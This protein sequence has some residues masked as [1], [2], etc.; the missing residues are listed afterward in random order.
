M[1][2]KKEEFIEGAYFHIYNH[3]AYNEI[4]FPQSE[5]YEYFLKKL[6]KSIEKIPVSIIAYCLMPNHFHFFVRQ[7]SEIPIYK[8]FNLVSLS[9]VRHYNI[10]Y[11]RY[12]SLYSGKLNHK[13]LHDLK[14]ILNL[15]KYIH[16]NP[17]IAGLVNM[18][19]KWEFSNYREWI[20]K[21]DGTLF[22]RKF[23]KEFNI[24]IK[25]YVWNITSYL[26]LMVDNEFL[27]LI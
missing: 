26:D 4:L 14:Y 5:D 10:K 2:C 6:K 15:C 22:A 27:K 23:I 3:A 21:R 9:Y 11:K 25:D 12:G 20:G 18:P 16:C 19:E 1:R 13:G 17:V 7:E 24:D 8:I